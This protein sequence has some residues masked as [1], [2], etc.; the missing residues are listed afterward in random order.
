MKDVL[1]VVVVAW[2]FPLGF[3]A[4]SATF[5]FFFVSHPRMHAMNVMEVCAEYPVVLLC[6]LAEQTRKAWL[7]GVARHHVPAFGKK[8]KRKREKELGL[9]SCLRVSLIKMCR[10]RLWLN[11]LYFSCCLVC[12]WCVLGKDGTH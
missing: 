5:V 4:C 1:R 8:I 7:A 10:A 3:S 11:S 2:I 9:P 12:A 6:L